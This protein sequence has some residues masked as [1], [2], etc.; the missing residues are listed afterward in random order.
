MMPK[1][2]P[3]RSAKQLLLA[4]SLLALALSGC[5][6]NK[7]NPNADGGNGGGNVG[8]G[9]GNVGGGGGGGGGGSG[10]GLDGGGGGGADPND[11]NNPNKD[12]D[13]D[14]LSDAEEF[15]VVY[16]G[17]KKTDPNNP[18]TDGDGI[19]DGVEAGRT[20]SV[21]PMCTN[22][23][24]DADPT[25]KT[26][27]TEVD[28]DADGLPDGL[29]DTNHD[30]KLDSGETDPT[31]PD[32]DFDTI[33]DGQEDANHNGVVD[34]GETDPRKKDTDGDGINDGIEL[35]VTLTDPTKADT[36]GDSCL[37]GAE[38][39]NQN[40]A[41]DP[42]E[43][44]PHNPADCGPSNNPDTDGD[45][46]PNAVED[47]NANGTVD[48]GETDP[49]NPD[50]DGDGLKDGIEDANHNGIV[51]PGE[52]NPLRKDSDCDGLLDGPS[53][54]GLLGEDQNANGIVDPGET[55]PRKFD[56]DGDGISDGVER[57]LTSSLIADTT[58][59]VNV[60]VDADPS[61]TTDPTKAD[62]DGDGISDGAEDTNQ[63]GKV[64]PG[65]LDPNNPNDGTGPVGQV[66]TAMNLRPVLFKLQLDSDLQLGL[67][68]TFTEV[69]V[70]VSG[71]ANKGLIGFDATNQVAF[72]AWRQ[73]APGAAT[74]PTADETAL[75]TTFSGVAAIS[76]ATTQ[77]FTTWDS[78]PALQAFY[79]QAGAVDVKAR[80]N[81]LANALA[82]AGSGNLAGAGT[83]NGPFRIQVEYLHRTNGAVVV[84]AALTPIANYANAPLFSMS[85]TSGGSAVAQFGDY[86]A[87]QCEKFAP[88]SGKVDFLFVVDDSCSMASS[89]T[90]LG[91]AATAMATA[92]GN[93]TLDYRMSMVTTGYHTPGYTNSGIRRGFTTDINQFQSWLT[94]NSN[95]NQ[96]GNTKCSLPAAQPL[97]DSNGAAANGSN[98]GCW[99]T[100]GGQTQEGMLGAA[101]KAV[102]DFTPATAT[103]AGGQDTRRRAAG[104]GAAGRRRRPDHRLHHH[105]RRNW[106]A[107]QH[108]IDYFTATGANTHNPLG[109]NVAVHGIICPDGQNC[110]GETEANPNREGQVVAAT[111]GIR[112]DIGSTTSIQTAVTNIVN[113]TIAAAGYK[114][115]KPP[116]GASVKVAMD[117]VLNPANCNINDIPRS[118][119]NGFDFDGVNRTISFFG[120]C[121]PSGTTM[122]A[123]VSYRYW[124]DLTPNPGGNPPPCSQ[125]TFYD[126]TDPDFCLGKLECDFA[127]N[128]C[129]CPSNC[130]GNGPPG[131][132]CDTNRL[133]CDFVCTSDCG[134]TCTGYQQCNTTNCTCECLQTASCA[135]GYRF[136]NGG[137]VC[138]C[139]C[140]TAALGCGPTYDA[141]P[142][143]AAASASPTAAAAPPAR[144]ATRRPAPAAAA[145]TRRARTAA[146]C[147]PFPKARGSSGW[148]RA[149]GPRWCARRPA[150]RPRRRGAPPGAPGRP[151]RRRRPSTTPR[152]AAGRHPRAGEVGLGQQHH[153]LVGVDAEEAVGAP[154]GRANLLRQLGDQPDRTPRAPAGSAA[155]L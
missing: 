36:D 106:E 114:M 139:V 5:D 117:S 103:R 64:D 148:P 65:E 38:D 153:E 3:A 18:D 128:T 52:T 118:R 58:N 50:T 135:V 130:G 150:G 21:D 69:N 144:S 142:A 141:D 107:V 45:G 48:P 93:S 59:C 24:G 39:F 53:A 72:V 6:C 124:I 47:K 119:A 42:G 4:A 37:D 14:G 91:T 147:R 26:I 79:D 129:I 35:N 57:G 86:N 20:S 10:G 19:P 108:F 40:G 81:A 16:P 32:T 31:N 82:G 143:A 55:D 85:D 134:G 2:L 132:V 12:T 75:R 28:S 15:G 73:A 145:S 34:P 1:T 112:G 66:C 109:V 131:Y 98:G 89:Q 137:G 90:A 23:V 154:Q 116:I 71:G 80:A 46:L 102:D 29:E 63:N 56:T 104:G 9:G 83:M 88:S 113:A 133:V 120:D 51:D 7:P 152:A 41:V 33:K 140:D 94:Q 111:G 60:P 11:L 123:A 126:P 30:G 54:G 77:T 151:G 70:M 96:A 136:Q 68:A 110:N 100:T 61:T 105:R 27:P 95:C 84:I 13:C 43:T 74:T 127:S 44:D 99:V 92:L 149:A 122:A 67:P 25:T 8:G 138:G 146:R 101:R 121:R 97:C 125:D 115:Q 76:N 49:N 22:F 78:V 155:S 62:T 17:G 87:V